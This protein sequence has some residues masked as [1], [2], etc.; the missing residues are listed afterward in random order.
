MYKQSELSVSN[1]KIRPY[2]DKVV[3]SEEEINKAED[4]METGPL[5]NSE[6]E[7]TERK[8]ELKENLETGPPPK[9]EARPLRRSQRV[10]TAKNVKFA[11]IEKEGKLCMKEDY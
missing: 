2:D 3:E 6:E 5:P 4:N 10:K 8:E 11:N 7:D 9:S 1:T